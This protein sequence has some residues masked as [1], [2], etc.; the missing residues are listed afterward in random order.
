MWGDH[1]HGANMGDGVAQ[2]DRLLPDGRLHVFPGARHS[3]ETEFP[4]E[5]AATILA[6]LREP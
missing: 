2:L 1:D 3:L 6:F 5:L 4:D